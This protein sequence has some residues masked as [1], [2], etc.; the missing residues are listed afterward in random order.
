M[1]SE[2]GFFLPKTWKFSFLSKKQHIYLTLF[3]E[4]YLR[5]SS[6]AYKI[7]DG[8][9][10]YIHLTNNAVQ[11]NASGYGQF[12]DGNQLSF[13]DLQRYINENYPEAKIDVQ[14]DLVEDMKYL[15]NKTLE[16]VR[17]K[18]TGSTNLDI[19]KGM[20]GCFEILGFDFMLD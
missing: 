17:T 2:Y 3:R 1:T 15:V 4:G 11:K 16:S 14:S 12:E 6:A 10:P 9:D 13:K 20:T 5:T 18:I 19:K 7:D 8:D